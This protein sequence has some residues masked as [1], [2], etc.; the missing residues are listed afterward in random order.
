MHT[1]EQQQQNVKGDDRD[2]DGF[3]EYV[4]AIGQLLIGGRSSIPTFELDQRFVSLMLQSKVPEPTM[5][6]A[7]NGWVKLFSNPHRDAELLTEEE[8]ACIAFAFHKIV[9]HNKGIRWLHDHIGG[10]R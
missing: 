7:L 8:T 1:P 10:V 2:S 5:Q 6:V 9:S 3:S 4:N